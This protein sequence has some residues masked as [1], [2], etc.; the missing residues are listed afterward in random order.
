MSSPNNTVENIVSLSPGSMPSSVHQPCTP[1]N[2]FPLH[3]F[4]LEQ[5]PSTFYR[6]QSEPSGSVS[7]A[8]SILGGGIC[9]VI[10]SDDEPPCPFIGTKFGRN[11]LYLC[12]QHRAEYRTAYTLYKDASERATRLSMQLDAQ[13][14][15]GP[16][17][18]WSSAMLDLAIKT[19][20]QYAAALEGEVEGRQK[21]SE[22]FIIA[23]DKA[24]VV[25]LQGQRSRCVKNERILTQLRLRRDA[26]VGKE[27]VQAQE[28]REAVALA[29]VEKAWMEEV[30]HMRFKE[31][32]R[33]LSD[34]HD[35]E[36]E[37]SH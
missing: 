13:S 14:L 22:R 6:S 20:E 2:A 29:A 37:E 26:M 25:W 16:V 30:A 24:H 11:P 18:S 27:C 35:Q 7:S 15:W 4:L 36:H 31:S 1:P 8:D 21:H 9:Q 23:V 12:Q 3:F 34:M 10:P 28:V 5:A 17:A 33:W 19:R 32:I